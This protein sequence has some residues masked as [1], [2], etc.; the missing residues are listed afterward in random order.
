M[1]GKA[2]IGEP[3]VHLPACHLALSDESNFQEY[4]WVAQYWLPEIQDLSWCCWLS[5]VSPL[6]QE[7]N[8]NQEHILTCPGIRAHKKH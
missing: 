1:S 7:S 3:W 2:S 8:K 5:Q 4:S 6:G